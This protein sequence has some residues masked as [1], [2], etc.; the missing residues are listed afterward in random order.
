MAVATEYDNSVLLVNQQL[1]THLGK[2]T[3]QGAIAFDSIIEML[4]NNTSGK[5]PQ[6]TIQQRLLHHK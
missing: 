3:H 2:A 1:I 4:S 6:V 5:E